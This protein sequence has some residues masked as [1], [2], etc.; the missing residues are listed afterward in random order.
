MNEEARLAA[1]WRGQRK[2]GAPENVEGSSEADAA[3][4]AL[5]EL[6]SDPK[7]KA[8]AHFRYPVDGQRSEAQESLD[9]ALEAAF[10]PNKDTN[11]GSDV[12]TGSGW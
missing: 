11:A 7:L 5:T 3:M 4:R 6:F 10:G 12:F 2:K 9:A 1:L 8:K